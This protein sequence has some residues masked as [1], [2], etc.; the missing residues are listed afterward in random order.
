MILIWPTFVI[1]FT[2]VGIVFIATG[3]V[4]RDS[5]RFS[6]GLTLLGL[7][8]A[9]IGFMLGS[10]VGWETPGELS[11]SQNLGRVFLFVVGGSGL[12]AVGIG[13]IGALSNDFFWDRSERRS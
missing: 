6:V 11:E 9:F 7:T 12:V 1:A 5:V 8:I 10:L 2:I 4:K 13:L 3:A